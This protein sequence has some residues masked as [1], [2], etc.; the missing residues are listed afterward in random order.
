MWLRLLTCACILVAVA[1]C[2]GTG[3]KQT[4]KQSAKAEIAPT[5]SVEQGQILQQLQTLQKTI[6]ETSQASNSATGQLRQHI[7]R[8]QG[9][10]NSISTVTSNWGLDEGWRAD[11]KDARR[12]QEVQYGM[13]IGLLVSCMFILACVQAFRNPILRA[14]ALSLALAL[15]VTIA[16]V[17]VMGWVR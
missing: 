5:A 8:V 2:A 15:P 3:A 9:D 13:M 17:V 11:L 10:V 4:A 1:G 12:K 16:I 7:E 6:Q 14:V